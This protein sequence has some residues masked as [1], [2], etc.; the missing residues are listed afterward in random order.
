MKYFIWLM[1]IVVGCS[2]VISRR[3]VDKPV[4]HTIEVDPVEVTAPKKVVEVKTPLLKPNTNFR[5]YVPK[6]GQM[7]IPQ[8]YITYIPRVQNFFSLLVNDKTILDGKSFEFTSDSAD[9]IRNKIMSGFDIEMRIYNPKWYNPWTKAIAYHDNWTLNFNVK[10]LSRTDCEV[11]GTMA[12]ESFHALD[13]IHGNDLKVS[14]E[15][16]ASL[17]YWAGEKAVELCKAGKI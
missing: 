2:Q 11:I 13:Y 14:S 9:Q 15:D 7:A 8:D 10:R 6:K 17:P 5:A 3:D 16:L 12:H 4:V 1:L